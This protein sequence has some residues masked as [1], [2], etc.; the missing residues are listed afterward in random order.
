MHQTKCYGLSLTCL[1][2]CSATEGAG[3]DSETTDFGAEKAKLGA[4]VTLV[5]R[6]AK[7]LEEVCIVGAVS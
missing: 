3:P 4:R 1:R 6:G 2:G 5:E 7:E